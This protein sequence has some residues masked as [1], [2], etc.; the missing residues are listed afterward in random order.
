MRLTW[1]AVE[2]TA[3]TAW[4]A[5]WAVKPATI[6][7]W[8]ARLNVLPWLL[9]LTRLA[10]L[11]RS[12]VLLRLHLL[13]L[14]IL[15]WLVILLRLR[16]LLWCTPLLR[17]GVAAAWRSIVIGATAIPLLGLCIAAAWRRAVVLISR[18]ITIPLA[19]LLVLRSRPLLW[20][21]VTA[22]WV[23]R[24]TVITPATVPLRLLLSRFIVTA[25]YVAFINAII[26]S[27]N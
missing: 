13:R 2:T 4:L 24:G 22:A 6:T 27:A 20:L 9:H 18:V 10:L 1:L 17:L 26:C 16:I 15:P 7:A 3:V 21:G 11:L 23:L 8:L 14:R 25:V 5:R 19:G 12:A